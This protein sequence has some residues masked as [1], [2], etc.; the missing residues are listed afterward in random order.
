MVPVVAPAE[1]AAI[2]AVADRK[3][4]PLSR[5]AGE[6]MGSAFFFERDRDIGVGRKPHDIAFDRGDQPG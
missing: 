4:H 2:A 1:V 5:G 6:G 3:R